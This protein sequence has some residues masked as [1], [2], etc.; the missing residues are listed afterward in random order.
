M[1]N[2]KALIDTL[3]LAP[4]ERHALLASRNSRRKA[5]ACYL[6]M[7]EK[8]SEDFLPL[9]SSAV[10]FVNDHSRGH[11]ERVLSHIE[12][13]LSRH[14]AKPSSQ[15]EDIPE[16]RLLTWPD[17]LILLNALVWHDIGNMYGRKGHA[18]KVKDCL[19]QVSGLLY[20]DHL[21]QYIIQVAEAHSGDGAIE[22][23]IPSCHA[24]GSYESQDIHLQFLAAV[25]RFADEL[26]ED[27]RRCT[28]QW[29]ELNLVPE[30]SRRFWYFCRVNSSIQ[31][32]SVAGDHNFNHE[33]EINSHVPESEFGLEFKAEQGTVHAMA[34]YFKRVFKLERERTYCNAYLRTA[35]Y[36]PGIA[37]IKV[38]LRTQEGQNP[39]RS[40]DNY[41]F[42]LSDGKQPESLLGIE[43]LAKLR[44]YLNE[45]L[46]R[47]DESL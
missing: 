3:L 29:R 28:P 9:V 6:A 20:D 40:S 32:K 17:T 37:R 36:H 27:H 2:S 47:K 1:P 8:V 45:A 18:A 4:I 15:S 13:I 35:Y 31:V 14:F 21:A 23:V 19:K 42:E 25:L 5:F 10:P 33:V 12:T 26:D 11:L 30:E 38:H 16:G 39:P 24:V 22:R 34:E 41:E 46:N 43:N 7:R 44:P